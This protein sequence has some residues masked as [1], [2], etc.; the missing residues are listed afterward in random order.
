VGGASAHDVGIQ[1]SNRERLIIAL[2]LGITCTLVIIDLFNDSGEGVAYWH[3]AL[4]AS[5]ALSALVGLFLLLRGA[6]SLRRQLD[7]EIQRSS[8]Y[9]L[10]ADSWRTQAR[11]YVAGLALAID[12]QLGQWKLSNAEKEI[13][14]LLLKGFGLKEIAR[15]RNTSEKTVRTQSAAIYAK[16]GLTGR[17]ELAAFFLEDLLVPSRNL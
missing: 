12:Q 11:H 3:V 17:S 4:E 8:A 13:A 7:E 6:L 5:A 10:E 1:V 9:R 15:L 2:A 14:F 16:A